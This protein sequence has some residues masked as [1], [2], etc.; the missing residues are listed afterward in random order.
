M[1]LQ[2]DVVVVMTRLFSVVIEMAFV[3]DV[4]RKGSVCC[5]PDVQYMATM[6]RAI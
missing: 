5:Y 2:H 3:L 1:R 6:R 4:E